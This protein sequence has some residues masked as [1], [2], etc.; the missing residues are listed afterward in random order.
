MGALT[1]WDYVLALWDM[2]KWHVAMKAD[3]ESDASIYNLNI[4]ENAW[5][6]YADQASV[7]CGN[8]QIPRVVRRAGWFMS[9]KC[10]SI[11]VSVAQGSTWM[12]AAVIRDADIQHYDDAN[13]RIL[14]IINELV[15]A[16]KRIAY[17][18]ANN[19][20]VSDRGGHHGRDITALC[21]NGCAVTDVTG[22]TPWSFIEF[23]DSQ[24]RAVFMI[25]PFADA[26][27]LES[28]GLTDFEHGMN[29]W[30][31]KIPLIIPPIPF[32]FANNLEVSKVMVWAK[33]S[34]ASD[35]HVL[36]VIAP[37]STSVR[38]ILGFT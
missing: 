2:R 16:E 21:Q 20:D 11:S 35:Y 9:L 12:T 5:L 6:V 31:E 24:G 23:Y 14:S 22:I 10:P 37:L 1:V 38:D 17:I 27:Y 33:P 7:T 4:N 30:W 15:T 18:D 32:R 28:G 34:Q 26:P 3:A 29:Y 8:A 13:N 36:Y 19:Y 25:Q